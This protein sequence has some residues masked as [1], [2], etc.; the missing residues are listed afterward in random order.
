MQ[1]YE[2][3]MTTVEVRADTTTVI[4]VTLKPI[5]GFLSV[6]SDPSGAE[7]YIDRNY[8]GTTPLENYK[9]SPGEYEVKIKKEGYEEYSRTVSITPGEKTTLIVSLTP[10]PEP[11]PLGTTTATSSDSEKTIDSKGGGSICGPALILGLALLPLLFR[12]KK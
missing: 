5:Y 8:V 12:K 7:V 9:I 6:K 4:S 11:S 10:L 2:E 1:D 3:Y